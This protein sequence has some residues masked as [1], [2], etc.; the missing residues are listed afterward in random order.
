MTG[1]QL[2]RWSG[3]E[4][5]VT[6]MVD[7]L[8]IT[9]AQ[10]NQSV[11]DL[12]ANVAAMLA[13]RERARDADLIVFPEL[14]LIGYPPEDLIMKPALVERATAEL[15]KLARVTA[16][17]GPAMLVGSVFVRDGALHNGVALLEGGRV[18]ATRFK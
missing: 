4:A 1:L 5:Y 14:Q 2:L 7:T 12:A 17:G 13:V 15:E 3:V 6:L 11:G 9:L 16:D 10:L 18:A 8:R